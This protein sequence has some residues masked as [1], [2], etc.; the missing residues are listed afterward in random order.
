MWA[1]P[2]ITDYKMHVGF[3]STDFL[4]NVFLMF[5]YS[6]GNFIYVNFYDIIFLKLVLIVGLTFDSLLY[7]F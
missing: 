6:D 2:N 7:S 1:W 3:S 4:L 5:H